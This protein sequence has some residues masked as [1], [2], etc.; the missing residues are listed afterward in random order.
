MSETRWTRVA[1]RA[2]LALILGFASL[3]AGL[4]RSAGAESGPALLPEGLWALKTAALHALD[5][6]IQSDGAAMESI[7]FSTPASPGEVVRHFRDQWERR[8]VEMVEGELPDGRSLVVLDLHQ[9]LRWTVVA[10][11]RGAETEVI[12]SLGREKRGA[13]PFPALPLELPDGIVVV[14]HTGDEVGL[15]KVET[16]VAVEAR[17]GRSFDAFCGA[18]RTAG[19]EGNCG[20]RAGRGP[21]WIELSRGKESLFVTLGEGPLSLRWLTIRREGK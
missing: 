3:Y 21:Q 20:F 8:E 17:P 14:S 15:R 10:R 19:W 5:G 13:E 18:A 12:R 16:W 1:G 2:L 11:R 9:G 7:V 4:P 6:A